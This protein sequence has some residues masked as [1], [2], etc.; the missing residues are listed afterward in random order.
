MVDEITAEVHDLPTT[1]LLIPIKGISPL[2]VHKFDEKAK[3]MI[4][5][6]QQGKK[7]L[8]EV[9][10]PKEDYERC[11]YHM[12][13]G[14]GQTHYGFPVVAFKSAAI[15]A[16]RFYKDKG[17]TMTAMRQSIFV[18]GQITPADNK[19]LVEIHGEP[20]MREDEVRIGMG[21]ADV[22]YR[23]EFREWSAELK[24]TFINTLIERGTVID[25]FKSAGNFVGVGEYRPE[26]NGTNGR[27]AVDLDNLKEVM[28]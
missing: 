9:R 22:R 20:H 23:P 8:K 6:S 10:N 11:F 21:S 4:L 15:S 13:L 24:V 3:R 27:F 28:F 7:K 1:T 12:D 5:E 26:R 14:D 16:V 18:T 2:I 17:M 25:L 19:E